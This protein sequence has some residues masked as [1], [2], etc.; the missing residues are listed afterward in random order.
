V[1]S[2]AGCSAPHPTSAAQSPA[3]AVCRW[4]APV[5]GRWAVGWGGGQPG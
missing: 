4:A 3:G 1:G 5:A 2:G